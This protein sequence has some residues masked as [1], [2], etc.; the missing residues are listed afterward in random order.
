MG[1]TTA[2][3]FILCIKRRVIPRAAIAEVPA[4]GFPVE[5]RVPCGN[6]GVDLD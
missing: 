2:S 3:P 4:S 1:G 6:Q 5:N